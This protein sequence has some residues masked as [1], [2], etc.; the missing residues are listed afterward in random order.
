MA[1]T[2]TMTIQQISLPP[3]DSI[4]VDAEQNYIFY[5]GQNITDA[6]TGGW[7]D[8]LSRNCG[9]ITVS[10]DRSSISAEITYTERYL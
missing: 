1:V 6:A 2:Q 5:R 8:D 4:I 3:G 10:A 7:I 9:R